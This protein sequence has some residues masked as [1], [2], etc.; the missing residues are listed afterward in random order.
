MYNSGAVFILN[1][2]I[3]LFFFFHVVFQVKVICF[4]LQFQK[5]LL[6]G[7]EIIPLPAVNRCHIVIIF[8]KSQ[9]MECLDENNPFFS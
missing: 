4:D 2:H 7:Q 3:I 1:L 5:I 8:V 9:K 6:I